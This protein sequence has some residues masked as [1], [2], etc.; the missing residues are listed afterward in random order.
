MDR[1]QSKSLLWLMLQARV[2][3]FCEF[4]IQHFIPQH[5]SNAKQGSKEPGGSTIFL[6]K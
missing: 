2:E 5:N 1:S 3:A 6:S 4:S